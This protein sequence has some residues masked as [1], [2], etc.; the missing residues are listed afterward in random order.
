MKQGSS[1]TG[2]MA[3]MLAIQAVAFIG[4]EP[5][6]LGGFLDVTGLTVARLR[7]A[8]KEPNFLSGVL[9]YMLADE[10]LLVEFAESAGID[11]SDVARARQV[12]SR[13]SL[14]PD[15]S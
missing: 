10:S 3:E 8:A 11:P 6:R 13:H 7:T 14:E 1:V 12:L 2:E 9:D 5:G 15:V 4:Q